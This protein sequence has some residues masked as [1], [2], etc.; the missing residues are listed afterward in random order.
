M[1]LHLLSVLLIVLVLLDLQGQLLRGLHVLLCVLLLLLLLAQ[2]SRHWERKHDGHAGAGRQCR[3]GQQSC[4][5]GLLRRG[6]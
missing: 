3:G 1:Q 5:L 2:P 6:R 4:M